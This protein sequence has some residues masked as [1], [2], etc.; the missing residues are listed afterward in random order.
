MSDK[1]SPPQVLKARGLVETA[2]DYPDLGRKM[3][4][5]T[6]PRR[7]IVPFGVQDV[8][9]ISLQRMRK[10]ANAK[11]VALLNELPDGATLT[12]EQRATLAAY[13]GEGGISGK[14]DT[15]DGLGKQYEYFTPQHVA[16]GMWDMLA[17]YGAD[18]GNGLEPSAGTGVFNETKP[19]SA[20]MTAAE[21][22]PISARINQLLHPEDKVNSGAFELIASKT[23]DNTFDF[24]IGNVPFGKGRP[25][26]GLDK[27]YEKEQNIGR[28]FI[29]RMI[30]KT[31]P[32][33]LLCFIAPHGVV[34]GST[35]KKFR[36]EI[37]KKA[38]FLG[39][40]RLNSDTFSNSGTNTI[41]DVIVMRKHPAD[42]VDRIANATSKELDEA[43]ILWDTF[44]DGKWFKEDGK[45][46]IYG[47]ETESGSGKFTRKAVESDGK[48]NEQIRQA[49]SHKFHSRII[50]DFLDLVPETQP[51]MY[52]DGE[53][54]VI[55]DR[56][57]TYENGEWVSDPIPNGNGSLDVA[58]FGAASLEDL[59]T[60]FGSTQ[61]T[62]TLSLDQIKA[63]AHEYPHALPERTKDA[64]AFAMQQ[65]GAALHERVF[66]GYLVGQAIDDFKQIA[67]RY[68]NNDDSLQ[69][70]RSQVAELVEQQ[71]A[72][73]GIARADKKLNKLRGKGSGIW[74]TFVN[75]T[76]TDGNL[77]DLL[78]G[79]LETKE[80]RVINT[81]DPVAVVKELFTQ[82]LDAPVSMS[83]FMDM[84]DNTKVSDRANGGKLLLVKIAQSHP[85]IAITPDGYLVPADRAVTGS[86]KAKKA[87]LYQAIA[88]EKNPVIKAHFEQ[89]LAE[90]NKRQK[91]TPP[92]NITFKMTGR[93]FDRSLVAEFL[94][95]EGYDKFQY[96]QH[97]GEAE[98]GILSGDTEY[99]GGDGIFVGYQYR[100]TTNTSTGESRFAKEKS[101]RK[102]ENLAF[103]IEKY[104]NGEKPQSNKAEITAEYL[105][106]IAQ[107]EARFDQFV[108]QHD[109]Y[110][111]MVAT[112]NDTFNDYIPL[113]YSDEPLG[114]KGIS[115]N[116]MPFGYQNQAVRRLSEDG[117]GILGFG[118]GMGKTT[119]ALA[120]A[121]YNNE[122]GRSTRTAIVV[123][124][125]VLENWYHEARDFYSDAA[126][127]KIL[128]VGLDVVTDKDGN[129][130]QVPVLD[131]QGQPVLNSRTQQPVMRDSLKISDSGTIRDRMQSIPHS[132][133]STVVMTKE[134][135][136]AIPLR[137]ETIDDV[138]RETVN[139]FAN[140]GLVQLDATN[141]TTAQRLSQAKAKAADTGTDK[142]DE[143]P[144]FED[145]EFDSVIAD[146]G[147]NYRNSYGLGR[148]TAGI[149]Y[150]SNPSVAA[151]ARDMAFKNN[152]L[153]KKFSGRGTVLLTATPTVNSP[154]DAFNMLSHVMPKSEW[155][156]LGIYSPDDFIEV[157]GQVEN[158]TKFKI[159]GEAVATSG[160]VGFQNLDG[161]R[162][163]FHRMVN[164]KKPQDVG[165]EAVI[166]D[167]EETNVQ[168][169]MSKE[170]ADLYDNLRW[171]AKWAT[172]S[173][174]EKQFAMS[175]GAEPPLD[176][177]GREIRSDEI[178]S[179]IRDMDRVCS[180]LDLYYHQLTYR[181]PAADADNVK[182]LIKKLPT[183]RKVSVIGLDGKKT[184]E[185]IPVEIKTH[186]TA[187]SIEIVVPEEIADNVDKLLDTL[188]INSATHP[189]TPKFAAML[190]NV[191][192]H[193]DAGGKQI[194]FTDEKSLHGK[195][196]RLIA[197]HLGIEESKIG[198]INATTVANRGKNKSEKA[199]K[200]PK[201]P[202]PDTA[203]AEDWEQ[204]EQD[205]FAYQAQQNNVEMA[206][207]E[208]IAADYNEGRTPIVI[209]NKK[210]EVGI[211]LHKGTTAIHHLT[212]PWTPAS[213]AQRN[214]RGARVGAKQKKVDVYYYCG[215]GSFD[216]YRLETLKR[217]GDWINDLFTSNEA[218]MRNADVDDAGDTGA[219]LADSD[220]E[221]AAQKAKAKAELE[222]RLL[223]QAK[224]T[225]STNLFQYLK[226]ANASTKS[227]E[228]LEAD[229]ASATSYADTCRDNID[230]TK[231]SI[232]EQDA[233]GS[234]L[235]NGMGSY[236]R[237]RLT[238]QVKTLANANKQVRNA[239]K[240]LKRTKD[241]N[242]TMKR[243]KPQIADALNRGLI[244]ADDSLLTHPEKFMVM[245]GAIVQIGGIYKELYHTG[246]GGRNHG[247]RGAICELV[248]V[249]PDSLV[250][251]LK[252]INSSAVGAIGSDVFEAGTKIICEQS[253]FADRFKATSYTPS[254]IERIKEFA[255][256]VNSFDAVYKYGREKAIELAKSGTLKLNSYPQLSLNEDAKFVY[257]KKYSGGGTD[258]AV[259]ALQ[260]VVC[261]EPSDNAMLRQIAA[262]LKSDE[263]GFITPNSSHLTAIFGGRWRDKI[264]DYLDTASPEAIAEFVA[265][266][267]AKMNKY[268]AENRV[269][270]AVAGYSF[271]N[272]RTTDSACE[273]VPE[274]LIEVTECKL[275]THVVDNTPFSEALMSAVATITGQLASDAEAILSSMAR[276]DYIN[277][278]HQHGNPDE[279][280]KE[281]VKQLT[282]LNFHLA[283]ASRTTVECY[284]AEP[285]KLLIRPYSGN[286]VTEFTPPNIPLALSDL[287]NLGFL[288]ES[289]VTESVM[290]SLP[291]FERLIKQAISNQKEFEQNA[292][293]KAEDIAAVAISSEPEK[294]GD[295]IKS[296][297]K[298]IAAS[299]GIT[300]RKNVST[301]RLKM[302]GGRYDYYN[303][304]GVYLLHDAMGKDGKLYEAKELLKSQFKAAYINGN[305][306]NAAD[307][308]AGRCYWAISAIYDINNVLNTI[309]ETND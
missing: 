137:P 283:K 203:T 303:A 241:A 18:T 305:R 227:I 262:W 218:R 118:T 50:W 239:E 70:L 204:Y 254:D 260:S 106:Q 28:Y 11:A 45:H 31:R 43:K 205:L 36:A 244:A 86:A 132:N 41:T 73:F 140:G 35:Y 76:D 169:P 91:K 56:W 243:L 219:L 133:W 9:G 256:P 291:D 162:N 164:M 223:D 16:Q 270:E 195:V 8:K 281:R 33:G 235:R 202:N 298:E 98:D 75:A 301:L 121:A 294:M 211:N 104:L 25:T 82:N 259:E 308:V 60:L 208:G 197:N 300:V 179:I 237:K 175:Q 251:T 176:H 278:E 51:H 100:T 189:I 150:L 24:A 66:R 130:L 64:L 258:E 236:Y 146:E 225:A 102:D 78:S 221:R 250:T 155:E 10:E 55:N 88:N 273:P 233:K 120:L 15:G 242:N 268:I 21:L 3:K 65:K 178:F 279:Q 288:S 19:R 53:R 136:A 79:T 128:F 92:E 122:T 90:I 113:E 231:K 6:A 47:T 69:E 172:M 72:E 62:L 222:A 226:A 131:E 34:S 269:A 295:D 108:R 145:M 159:S 74:L 40:H 168:A 112:Y 248:S 230:S 153:M 129:Q 134:Q 180:D 38:E 32:N 99:H 165:K 84:Y 126:F 199:L 147:H 290:R 46:F 17:A 191:K 186:Q 309:K 214:G 26:A 194:I 115:G 265:D 280:I 119:T 201:E 105:N 110:D 141:H 271:R 275:P 156:K 292:K 213:V 7:A 5:I 210:A 257:G 107:L 163:I 1:N 287:V 220:E 12:D 13:S 95:A 103:Q 127:E 125:A 173:K 170:Q 184:I 4:A 192:T 157:F 187:T 246:Y 217:K 71:K 138:A 96:I 255:E 67:A 198:I 263:S 61:G 114:L 117:R 80:E 304:G 182:A 59:Q 229:L 181:F 52:A 296:K 77:S 87:A 27:E 148:K 152:Y 135:Y 297:A 57:H 42:A 274:Y 37:S 206:G 177:E 101:A 39:A 49:L 264:T 249:D 160:L 306:S 267:V 285:R 144:F 109:D 68:G 302:N 30:D 93:W 266:S 139:H 224:K 151:S 238:E 123:P 158:I 190:A 85:E 193:F 124:K 234:N 188:K 247:D 207:L 215:K 209:C 20:V 44:I 167:L 282:A 29:H 2:K 252:T 293:K 63:I 299:L 183:T 161:L 81:T 143:Y 149:A 22:N 284:E 54:R 216:E 166:P 276:T 196:R 23:P 174:A 89:Q 307:E 261:P 14:S 97:S 111:K 200:E 116:R 240:L 228:Q 272:N 253:E 185:T 58:K 289:D 286:I 83:D 48:T 142:N 171:R 245:N 154:V 232:E 277:F 94:Q 212:L